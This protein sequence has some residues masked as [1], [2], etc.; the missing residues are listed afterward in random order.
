[1]PWKAWL[2]RHSLGRLF[3]NAEAIACARPGGIETGVA[4]QRLITLSTL[5][6]VQ[7]QERNLLLMAEAQAA[8]NV[9][10]NIR[11]LLQE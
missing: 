10:E 7:L 5:G 9:A 3:S 8:K 2:G 1:M 6:I 4:F 11:K